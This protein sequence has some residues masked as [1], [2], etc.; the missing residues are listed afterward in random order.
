MFC[1]YAM[2]CGLTRGPIP[3]T[4]SQLGPRL[5]PLSQ[6][7][8]GFMTE[9]KCSGAIESSSL[10]LTYS[11]FAYNSLD[12][13]NHMVPPNHKCPGCVILLW[14]PKTMNFNYVMNRLM[15]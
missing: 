1:S 14:A 12:R 7:L 8:L 6:I 9:E 5:Q 11:I 13:T 4:A 3:P 2:P 15:D 10:E